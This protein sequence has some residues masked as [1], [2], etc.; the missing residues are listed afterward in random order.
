MRFIIVNILLLIP[1]LS[2]SQQTFF[3]YYP[4][5]EYEEVYCV[6]EDDFKN[7]YM[8]GV[9][10]IS[11]PGGSN[12]GYILKTDSAGNLVDEFTSFSQV[13]NSG[14]TSIFY[15]DTIS[16]SLIVVGNEDSITSTGS[17]NR[18]TVLKLSTEMVI[19]SKSLFSFGEQIQNLPQESLILNDSIIYIVSWVFTQLDP[20]IHLSVLKVGLPSDSLGYF[21][22]PFSGKQT[23]SDIIFNNLDTTLLI[24]YGG[25]LFKGGGLTKVI[26]FDTD[27][28]Y[29]SGFEPDLFLMNTSGLCNYTDTSYLITSTTITP[30]LNYQHMVTCEYSYDNNLV[31][32]IEITAGNPDT[33][34]FCSGAK[35]TLF[36]DSLI[37]T[38][39][40]YN[41]IPAYYPWQQEPSWIQLNCINSA[42]ELIE[43][44]FYGGDAFYVPFDMKAT[45]D[46]GIIIVGSRY[47]YN[48]IPQLFQ[49]DPFVLKVNSEGLIVNVNNP[50]KPIAQE[51]IVLPNPGSEYLQVKLAIQ[52]KTAHFQLFDI[53]GRL[54]LEE[55]LQGDMQR[56]STSSLNSG[57]YIYRITASNRVIGSGKWVKD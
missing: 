1:V 51:A 54:V 22:S 39:G 43:Q 52:H 19:N 37:W 41:A 9:K 7:F 38:V 3:K 10:Y 4:S 13:K 42:F 20:A 31:N 27:L 23:S 21:I 30:A 12:S 48:A 32:Y 40:I 57:T 8:C 45:G 53:N 14:F 11:L 34:S 55:N 29:I 28:N 24:S 18:I 33:L 46:G 15:T 47:D 44:H 56:V 17:I 36:K 26:K 49:K 6:A 25:S 5:I 50:E 16:N 2:F 35:N